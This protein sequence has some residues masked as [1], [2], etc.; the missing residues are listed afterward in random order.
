MKV[1]LIMHARMNLITEDEVENLF[2]LYT[3]I[4]EY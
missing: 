2:K 3:L 4:H 1:I